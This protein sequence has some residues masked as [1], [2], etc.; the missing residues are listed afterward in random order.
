M[1]ISILLVSA[2][3][4]PYAKVGGLADV[5]GTLPGILK[6]LGMDV[7]LVLPR[8]KKINPEALKLRKTGPS[9]SVSLGGK[10]QEVNV[11]EGE[12]G[13]YFLD[14]PAH[15]ERDNVYGE[16]DDFQRFVL[17]S[18]AVVKLPDA[19]GKTFHIF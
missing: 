12:K 11:Y 14:N 15:F 10:T 18:K 9:F 8:Y 16:P 1:P 5:A 17:F 3:A 7:S 6:K 2:E 13:V 19:I 4:V